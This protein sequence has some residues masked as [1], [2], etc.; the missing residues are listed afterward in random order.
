MS[1]SR[2]VDLGLGRPTARKLRRASEAC[3]Q[4]R[5]ES[6]LPNEAHH[7]AAKTGDQSRSIN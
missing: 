2:T 7:L 1:N 4:R 3:G 5:R 6:Q